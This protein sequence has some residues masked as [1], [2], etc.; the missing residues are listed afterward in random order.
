MDSFYITSPFL[1]SCPNLLSN[2]F[3]QCK[4]TECKIGG[5]E[6]L[7]WLARYIHGLGEL[8]KDSSF[9][10]ELDE[11]GITKTALSLESIRSFISTFTHFCCVPLCNSHCLLKCKYYN[12]KNYLQ[13]SW[14]FVIFG[15]EQ[16]I[17]MRN[18]M[19]TQCLNSCL[20]VKF[21][22]ISGT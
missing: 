15:L 22:H 18:T 6:C 11:Y 20:K 12:F 7:I 5:R 9:F 19:E 21:V 2:F 14:F 17:A 16:S 8:V 13:H 1:C 10:E 4:D 3:S